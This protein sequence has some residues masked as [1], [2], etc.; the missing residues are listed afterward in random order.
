MNL[1]ETK[2]LL[3]GQQH[4]ASRHFDAVFEE[5]GNRK[6]VF[7]LDYDGTLAPIVDDPDKAIIPERTAHTLKQLSKAFNLGIITGRS[8]EKIQDF[9]Q[10]DNIY[11]AGSHGMDIIGPS[12]RYRVGEEYETIIRDL[13]SLF[14][15]TFQE[16][17]GLQEVLIEST[18]FTLS[19]HYR[20]LDP[21]YHKV[22]RESVEEI[23]E[24]HN[25]SVRL[26]HGKMVYEI[27][28]VFRWAKGDALEFLYKDIMHGNP[29]EL[30][31]IYIGDDVSDEDAFFALKNRVRCGLGILVA[32]Q[33]KPSY[34]HYVL[35]DPFEVEEFLSSFVARKNDQSSKVPIVSEGEKH[36]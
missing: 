7:F 34:A 29:E 13:R 30:F 19:V 2:S 28:P 27:R 33:P 4:S 22:L 11:Y 9:L 6:V 24:K 15:N 5:I 20:T 31:P 10:L 18:N 12:L 23:L 1:E 8:L 26:C 16:I 14:S 35:N 32:D 3:D 36:I 17:Q 25:D 21:Q